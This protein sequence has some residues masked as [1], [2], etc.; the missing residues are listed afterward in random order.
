MITRDAFDP[1]FSYLGGSGGRARL[2]ERT[3]TTI[4]DPD[5]EGGDPPP[6]VG[7]SLLICGIP[8]D[9]LRELDLSLVAPSFGDVGRSLLAWTMGPEELREPSMMLARWP[10]RRENPTCRR[11]LTSALLDGATAAGGDSRRPRLWYS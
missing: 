4:D 5:S 1:S 2:G 6:T 10:V 8:P 7:C 11:G 9:E 3:G